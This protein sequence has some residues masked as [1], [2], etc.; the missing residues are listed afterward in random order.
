MPSAAA[1][2]LMRSGTRYHRLRRAACR[3]CPELR[4]GGGVSPQPVVSIKEEKL[5]PAAGRP[6]CFSA[7]RAEP[8][9]VDDLGLEIEEAVPK[10][11]RR[12]LGSAGLWSTVHH[13]TGDLDRHPR[14]RGYDQLD[15][16]L[17]EL[18]HAASSLRSR[19]A[20]VPGARPRTNEPEEDDGWRLELSADPHGN[21]FP[22]IPRIERER[23]AW[24]RDLN[25]LGCCSRC[26][27]DSCETAARSLDQRLVSRKLAMRVLIASTPDELM[28]R[29]VLAVLDALRVVTDRSL[30]LFVGHLFGDRVD[31][32]ASRGCPTTPCL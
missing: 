4:P 31:W 9:S 26:R 15:G 29:A 5:H 27:T 18:R 1:K 12:D 32:A 3:R 14:P 17:R 25:L 30:Q 2:W 16:R 7:V 6:S 24:P 22:T 11:I 20:H 23:W 19:Q 10:P 8:G 13:S 28:D 21:G